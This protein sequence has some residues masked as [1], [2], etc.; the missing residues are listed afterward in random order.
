M[1]DFNLKKF[2]KENRLFREEESLDTESFIKS[3]LPGADLKKLED[4]TEE[5]GYETVDTYEINYP[6]IDPDSFAINVFDNKEFEFYY[7]S[8]PIATSL[9]TPEEASVVKQ[10]MIPQPHDLSKLTPELFKSVIDY[11]ESNY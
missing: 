6:G 3:R 1:K 2:L 9:H 10:S 4:S 11:I 7:D 8:A 5:E